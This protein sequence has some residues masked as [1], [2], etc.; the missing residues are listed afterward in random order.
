MLRLPLINLDQVYWRPNRNWEYVT[1]EEFDVELWRQLKQHEKTGWVMEGNYRRYTQRVTEELVTDFICK[2]SL[3]L[4][5]KCVIY[6][7]FDR[8]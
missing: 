3:V 5:W 8:A 4:R 7:L 1:D 2:S 6:L